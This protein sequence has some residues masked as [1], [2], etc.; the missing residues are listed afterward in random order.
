MTDPVPLTAA[1]IAVGIVAEPA[2]TALFDLLF[3]G[4]PLA[5]IGFGAVSGV[6]L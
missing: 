6:C 2:L 1:S 3:V 5:A 4:T